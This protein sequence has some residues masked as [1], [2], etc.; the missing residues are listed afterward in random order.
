[1]NK[2]CGYDF[3]PGGSSVSQ[4]DQRIDEGSAG[5]TAGTQQR[6]DG[7]MTD[8]WRDHRLCCQCWVVFCPTGWF[9]LSLCG[10]NC[11]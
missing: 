10:E 7:N 6:E 5:L 3:L 1:M 2:I 4:Q 8:R 9:S 11:A